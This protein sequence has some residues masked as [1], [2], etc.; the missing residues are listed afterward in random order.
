MQALE[1]VKDKG[2]CAFGYNHNFKKQEW[3]NQRRLHTHYFHTILWTP[4]FMTTHTSWV[5]LK[6]DPYLPIYQ[7][8]FM[9]MEQAGL[10]EMISNQ[11]KI[12]RPMESEVLEPLKLLHFYITMIGIAVGIFLS[13]IT[14]ALEKLL[15]AKTMKK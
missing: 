6:M 11:W 12:F 14:F 9:H 1:F 3:Y 13:F 2:G 5:V 4:F 10:M 8:K 7:L 15:F